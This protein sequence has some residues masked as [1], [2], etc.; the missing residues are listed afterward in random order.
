MSYNYTSDMVDPSS[1][2][3]SVSPHGLRLGGLT[4][5]GVQCCLPNVAANSFPFVTWSFV[6]SSGI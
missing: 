3:N 4:T 2:S 5:A 6:I 1:I